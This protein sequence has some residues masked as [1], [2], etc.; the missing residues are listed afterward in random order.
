MLGGVQVEEVTERDVELIWVEESCVCL[1]D[2]YKECSLSCGRKTESKL[3]SV[4]YFYF[5]LRALNNIWRVNVTQNEAW[6]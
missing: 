1:R 3:E 6:N 4:G 5:F 2:V